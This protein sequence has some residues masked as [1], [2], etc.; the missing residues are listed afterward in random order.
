MLAKD[1][2]VGEWFMI[3]RTKQWYKRLPPTGSKDTSVRGGRIETSQ[4]FYISEEEEVVLD[5]I[6]KR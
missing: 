5:K 2:P 6:T 3:V 1:V 4:V